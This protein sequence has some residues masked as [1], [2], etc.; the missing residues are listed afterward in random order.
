M[1]S[2]SSQRDLFCPNSTAPH[3]SPYEKVMRVNP[4]QPSMYTY[5]SNCMPIHEQ[6]TDFCILEAVRIFSPGLPHTHTHTLSS[7]SVFAL[8]LS[9]T[10]WPSRLQQQEG[11]KKCQRPS[12][13]VIKHTHTHTRRW[14]GGP[15]LGQGTETRGGRRRNNNM[16]GRRT[17]RPIQ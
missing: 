3:T 15:K 2:P 12:N 16:G 17:G 9:L 7:Y 5:R 13:A 1:Q 14:R 8:R 4:N 6:E 11:R 10:L